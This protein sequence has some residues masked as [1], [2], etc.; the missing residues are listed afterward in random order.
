MDTAEALDS[1]VGLVS[2]ILK[3]VSVKGTQWSTI[4][5]MKNKEILISLYK[6]YNDIKKVVIK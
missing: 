4:C 5:D 6:D 2:N 1:M 3:R